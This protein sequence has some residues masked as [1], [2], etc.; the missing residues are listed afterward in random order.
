M[1]RES[2][3]FMKEDF[4][5]TIQIYSKLLN[6]LALTVAIQV[7]FMYINE[8]EEPLT[9]YLTI[10]GI[11]MYSGFALLIRAFPSHFT[12]IFIILAIIMGAG[13]AEGNI[14]INPHHLTIST[15]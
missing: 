12:T 14:N 11:F 9:L 8:N 15:K 4:E 2:E 7:P 3:R 10:F 13:S 1:K 5:E 6:L